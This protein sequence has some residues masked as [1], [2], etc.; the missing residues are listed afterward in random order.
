MSLCIDL[1]GWNSIPKYTGVLYRKES[2]VACL[3]NEFKMCDLLLYWL[4]RPLIKKSCII[5]SKKEYDSQLIFRN[6]DTIIT[7]G[8]NYDKVLKY[9][10]DGKYK[11]VIVSPNIDYLSL[12]M[13]L[14]WGCRT[15][16]FNVDT[17]RLEFSAFHP[18]SRGG[19]SELSNNKGVIKERTK[20]GNIIGLSMY[21]FILLLFLASAIV[22][23][24]GG[25]I[26][27]SPASTLFHIILSLYGFYLQTKNDTTVNCIGLCIIYQHIFVIYMGFPR[28]PE[29]SIISGALLGL[30]T[31][32]DKKDISIYIPLLYSFLTK[33]PRY[34]VT[35]K[36][37]ITVIIMV[38]V[39]SV[40]IKKVSAKEVITCKQ[41]KP[42][43]VQ[44]TKKA[45]IIQ[46][47]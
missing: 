10:R 5:V 40:I 14:G 44:S 16:N 8:D 29:A 38:I 43:G 34:A 20:T 19:L 3:T 2:F 47:L 30:I 18:S 7:E 6:L 23:I 11:I 45:N 35:A 39:L 21:I 31:G 32:I 4:Y 22:F 15:M 17:K 46:I 41:T 42:K 12:C 33:V 27:K 9:V 37:Q 26:G 36:D 28:V 1:L 13:A 25:K 24:I